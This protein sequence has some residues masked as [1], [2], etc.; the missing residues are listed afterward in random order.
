MFIVVEIQKGL[1]GT[2]GNLV[3]SFYDIKAAESKYHQ[4]LAAAAVSE[5]P[6]HS[7]IMFSE[8]GFPLRHEC[9]KNEIE[10]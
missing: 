5:L 6:V 2:I 10:E 4:I 1:D 8:E 7:C 9:Y 3:Y